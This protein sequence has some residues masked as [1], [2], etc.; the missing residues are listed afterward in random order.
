MKKIFTLLIAIITTLTICSCNNT[1]EN[2]K[3]TQIPENLN[4][5]E[6]TAVENTTTESTIPDETYPAIELTNNMETVYRITGEGGFV[7]IKNVGYAETKGIT[8]CPSL[9]RSI[10]ETV[11]K[12]KTDVINGKS[13]SLIY[14]YSELYKS[15]TAEGNLKKYNNYDIY[16]TEDNKTICKYF[17]GT[18]TLCDYLK[19]RSNTRDKSYD[20]S[21]AAD[22]ANEFLEN[23]LGS[24]TFNK[25]KHYNYS[26]SKS[27]GLYKF[28]YIKY[29]NGI[30]TEDKIS[31]I[32]DSEGVY[33]YSARELGRYDSFED[34]FS[35]ELLDKR[36]TDLRLIINSIGLSQLS[37]GNEFITLS[38]DGTPYIGIYIAY[39]AG[40]FITG[41]GEIFFININESN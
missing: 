6:T 1:T 7:A 40:T 3:Q 17:S 36:V 27:S 33:S 13:I 2:N 8:L 10:L 18:N 39:N 32:V 5:E 29:I 12:E 37:I 38:D 23:L 24:E 20:G 28:S 30:A 15:N 25:I 11:T 41:T 4:N 22:I 35:K 34:T 16:K 14:Q 21:G 9:E 19:V 31:I 26:S